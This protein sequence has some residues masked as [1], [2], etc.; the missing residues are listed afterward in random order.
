MATWMK[1][2]L[3]VAA[4]A[5]AGCASSGTGSATSGTTAATHPENHGGEGH[6]EHHHHELPP[7]LTAFHDVLRPL[8]HSDAGAERDAR[9]CAQAATLRARA[10]A[11]IDG[12]VPESAQSQQQGWATAAAQLAATSDALVTACG[13]TPRGNVA[14]GLEAVH[15]A[16]HGLMDRLGQH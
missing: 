7:T 11:V 12:P 16:F 6:G 3:W 2:G 15:T 9:S 13:A 8:W 5:L 1:C 4:M 14:G 10:Q